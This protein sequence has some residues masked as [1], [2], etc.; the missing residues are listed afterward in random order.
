[1]R[2][3]GNLVMGHG[4][5]L[6][7]LASIP[8]QLA[9]YDV[10]IRDIFSGLSNLSST[11]RR[12]YESGAARINPREFEYLGDIGNP[13]PWVNRMDR[14]SNFLR[15]WQGRDMSDKIEAEVFYGIGEEW[16]KNMLA[17]KNERLLQR[18][19]GE[20]GYK[21]PEHPTQEDISKLAA[22][23]VRLTR[24]SYGPQGLPSWA[25]SGNI[26]PFA[27]LQR[28]GIEKWNNV[29]KDV[30]QPLKQGNLMPFLKYTLSGV[31]TGAMIEQMNE[32][33]AGKKGSDLNVS[34]SLAAYAETQDPEIL[35]QKIIGLMQLSS[36]AGIM[37]DFMK[38][39]S[40]A[41]AGKELSYSN[42]ISM[43]LYTLATDTFGENLS[44]A[45]GGLRS[46]ED[47]INVLAELVKSVPLQTI[48]AGRYLSG[49]FNKEE[50]QRKEE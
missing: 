27:A 12:A 5:A 30:V 1:M 48:Q 43:P 14:I 11:R 45:I 46:G 39:A 50:T 25:L 16:A 33:L 9:P 36:Y 21:I 28:F 37:G 42:P 4:T 32:L 35:S 17:T 41:A 31:M 7:N 29:A 47:P 8:T 22:G 49:H 24:G 34:E 20:P 23:F 38:M 44:A 13:D 10:K 2:L 6:R 15:K 3:A 40:R 19:S 26:A 18:A